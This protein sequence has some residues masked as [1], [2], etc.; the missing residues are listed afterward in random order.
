[1]LDHLSLAFGSCWPL[2][3]RSASPRSASRSLRPGHQAPGQEGEEGARLDRG[4]QDRQGLRPRPRRLLPLQR[5]GEAARDPQEGEGQLREGAQEALR[6]HRLHR[7]GV[8]R[9]D[10]LADAVLRRRHLRAGGDAPAADARR[11]VGGRLAA[12]LQHQSL[13]R[14]LVDAERAACV[15]GPAVARPRAEAGAGRC[16][17]G[18]GRSRPWLHGFSS[19]PGAR[20][21]VDEG[22]AAA[23]A[24]RA[25]DAPSG[26]G[27]SLPAE[28]ARATVS[29]AL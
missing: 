15:A 21:V 28:H 13:S 14:Q 23:A 19:W 10:L 26:T 1:M 18:S 3:P 17:P 5:G 25:R 16:R 20:V 29:A 7:V 6:R 2:L 12:C 24:E 9:S 8:D 11:T 22:R 27:W 4:L